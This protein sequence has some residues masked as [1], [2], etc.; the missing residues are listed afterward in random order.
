MSELQMASEM[1]TSFL[2]ARQRFLAAIEA[3]HSAGG[4]SEKGTVANLGRRR[5]L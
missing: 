3:A 1:E 5:N 2:A 4:P